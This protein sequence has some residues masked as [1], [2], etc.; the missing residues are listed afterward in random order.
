MALWCTNRSFPP[1]SGAMNPYPLSGLNH[2][3][4]PVAIDETPPSAAQERA[5]EAFRHPVLAQTARRL[6]ADA[7][8]AARQGLSPFPSSGARASARHVP[9]RSYG[10]SVR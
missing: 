9:G 1:S 4:V 5:G 7:R 6:A 3:T 2:L 10:V 8:A